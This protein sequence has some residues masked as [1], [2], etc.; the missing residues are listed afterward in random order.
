MSMNS[1]LIALADQIENYFGSQIST[2]NN[3]EVE[4]LLLELV[5]RFEGWLERVREAQR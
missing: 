5:Q 2:L 1:E 3:N 4:Y